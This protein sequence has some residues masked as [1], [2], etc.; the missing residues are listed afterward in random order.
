MSISSLTLIELAR[1]GLSI[2]FTNDADPAVKF[3]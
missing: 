3:E 1:L 2:Q